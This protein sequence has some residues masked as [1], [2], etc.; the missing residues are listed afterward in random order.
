MTWKTKFPLGQVVATCG[1]DEEMRKDPSFAQFVAQSLGRHA[2]GDWGCLC[3][4]DKQEN[5]FSLERGHR[6]FS[7]YEDE[8]GKLP[9][10]WIIT[11]WDRSVTTILFPSEY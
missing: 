8:E 4:E 10:I 6:L 5:E 7:A 9:K 1:V 11:E 3:E 2:A